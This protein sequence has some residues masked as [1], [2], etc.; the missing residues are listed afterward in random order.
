MIP[1]IIHF[2]MSDDATQID[3]LFFMEAVHLNEVM[4]TVVSDYD[5]V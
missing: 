2:H 3:E 1:H 4:S 5:T